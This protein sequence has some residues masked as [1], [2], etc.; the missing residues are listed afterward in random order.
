MSSTADR[1][2]MRP[3]GLYRIAVFVVALC[4]LLWPQSVAEEEPEMLFSQSPENVTLSLGKR[5]S[6]RCALRGSGGA[7][8]EPPDI[9]WQR[10]GHSLE[11]SDTDQLLVTE[12]DDSWVAISEL[13]IEEVQLSDMGSYRCVVRTGGQE[14]VSQEGYIELEGLPHFSQE[15]A[16][17]SVVANRSFTLSC[18][19]HGPPEPVHVI[20]L[21]DG[22]PL[23]TLTQPVAL[24][25]STLNITG[26]N[27]T[28]SFSCEAHNRK[29][30][31]TSASG[32]VTVIPAPPQRV[33]QDSSSNSSVGV[34]W[35]T[36]FGGVYP[37]TGCSIQAAPLDDLNASPGHVIYNQNVN[38][39]PSH[40]VIRGL[41]AHSQYR[42]RVACHS[43][44]GASPWT[45][46]VTVMT[47]QGVPD[48]PPSE[49]TVR[50]N[51]SEVWV[52]WEGPPGAMNGELLGYRLQYNS[53]NTAQV[54]VDTGLSREAAL[55]LSFPLSNVTVR[56]SAYTGAGHGPWSPPQTLTL[57][58]LEIRELPYTESLQVF[59]WHWWYVV[60]A[61][62]VAIAL[63]VLISVYVA[64]LRRKETRFGE[65]FEPM[66]ESGEM[67]V[68][69][70]ARRSYG[71]RATEA[72]LN[73][74]GI[75][76]ELKQKL[77][78]VMVDRHRLTLGK[79][80]GEGEF[81]SVM[82]GLLSQEEFV[83]KV[84]V[85][86]MKIAICTR[87][88]M[89]DFLR[90]AACMKEFDHLNV[91]RLIGVCLQTVES[92]GYPSPVVILPFMK[93]GDLHSYLLYSRLGDTPVFLPCQMLISFMLDVARGMEYLSSKN[94]IHRDLAARNCMLN[95]NMSVCVADFG[96]SKKIYNGDYYRQGRISKMPVKWIA[97][98]SLA[99]RVYTSK[100][101][102]WS[103]G[104]TM[105]EIATR[106]QTP[107]PGVENS[108]IYDYLRQG[109][110]LR[111]P[112]DCL[113]CIYALM[114]SCWLLSPKDRPS[115]EALRMS[116]EKVQEELRG[117]EGGVD[118]ILY[119]N[120][121]EPGS[122]LGAVG[123]GE[124]LWAEGRGGLKMHSHMPPPFSLPP[125][126]ASVE[127]HQPGRYVLCPAPEH[128]RLL[129]AESL[130]SLTLPPP[131]PPAT[132]TPIHNH[133]PA[134]THN[135]GAE[136]RE[137]DREDGLPG[138][139]RAPW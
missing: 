52:S 47:A 67:V 86:T 26:L 139:Q 38:V 81:G 102:V 120:M 101:D 45:P 129:P 136:E 54:E 125:L 68:R 31:A 32:T 135:E 58:P 35:D 44:Q 63:A 85:K 93:H 98:E 33:R 113:D 15:P 123:G 37:V 62:A 13:R 118:D 16:D 82:E 39:P 57:T 64:R 56:V 78:D 22:A 126:K 29:G 30:V 116:L 121:E 60:M 69:Y 88:E 65:A 41:A 100:S 104:V 12:S 115:F 122:E 48:A 36:S 49:V 19:A 71:R 108:E 34:S 107:Y 24:S 3:G 79:T 21:Q 17:L 111:Q 28:S 27:K 40:H 77:Q 25:P 75:S 9:T 99:D 138:K 23:N 103:F 110:R 72:T 80:L 105:W 134:H 109:N 4:P 84:A 106:G 66:M 114:F 61:A 128:Q 112:P 119:V 53:P 2:A 11:D 95:E 42:V 130:D 14:S 59:S 5:V 46:W 92:E 50:V 73:T 96:L 91:M 51:G 89:E 43:N 137:R 87:S 83:L 1:G 133:T 97:I 124:P 131:S 94:F 90:E 55:N 74:L 132:P 127:V 10:D 7:L 6:L 18:H 117:G 8:W 20:W 76:D 70:R